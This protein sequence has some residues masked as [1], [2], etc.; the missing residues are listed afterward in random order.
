VQPHPCPGPPTSA[1]RLCHLCPLG[2]EQ[3]RADGSPVAPPRSGLNIK[4]PCNP[5]PVCRCISSAILL[6][7]GAPNFKEHFNIAY[8]IYSYHMSSIYM[9][10][11]HPIS[12]SDVRYLLGIYHLYDIM[13]HICHI[14]DIYLSYDKLCHVTGGVC[15]VHARYTAQ[16]VI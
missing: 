13:S 12:L 7:A 11:I 2:S 14:P 8:K 3:A 1:A 5:K 10:Y 9:V 16:F 6:W 15:L 4:H